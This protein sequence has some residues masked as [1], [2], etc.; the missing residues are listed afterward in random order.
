LPRKSRPRLTVVGSVNLDHV[1]FTPR[2]PSPGETVSG[3]RFERHPGGKGANQALCATRLGAAVSLVAAVGS[4]EAAEASLRLLE[5]AGVDL[6]GVLRL[7]TTPTGVAIVLVD[8]DGEN[9]IV[10][11]P[12]ANL[13]LEPEHVRH[14]VAGAE[15]V[16]CQLEIAAGAV[17]AA[18][19]TGG[20][21][22]L[23]AA[24]AHP[25]AEGVVARADLVVVNEHELGALPAAGHDG[26]VALTFGARGAVLLEGGE[27]VARAAPPTVDAVD[28]TGAGDAFTA[29][30][31]VSLLEGRGHGEAL[32]RACAAGA[33]AAS[34][35]GAQPSLP[36]AAE[37]DAILAR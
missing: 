5:E 14:A 12:G 23:N 2:L 22:A 16:L 35:T 18:A 32:R 37:V 19:R 25:V 36:G 30:L 6:E 28:S 21:F 9:E 26:L 20:F 24:P 34:R 15:A 33:I 10:V 8:P 29:C 17:E 1:A 11:A 4:D 27:E 3:A 7:P 31:T 13:A